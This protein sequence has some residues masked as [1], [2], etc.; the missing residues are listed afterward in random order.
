MTQQVIVTGA[1][2]MLGRAVVKAAGAHGLDVV[3]LAGHAA[4]DIGYIRLVETVLGRYD[5]PL[6]INCA[7]VVPPLGSETTVPDLLHAQMWRANAQG[8]HNLASH[9]GRLVHVST[10]CVFDGRIEAGGYAED[11]LPSPVTFYGTSKLAGEVI[12]EPH[13][14]VRASFIG[15]GRRGLVRW[16]LDQPQGA[17]IPG[18]QD[19]VWNGWYVAD[20]ADRL[21]TLAQQARLTGLLHLPGP[22]I[23]TKGLLVGWLAKALRPDLTVYQRDAGHRRMVLGSHRIVRSVMGDP[24]RTAIMR[25][26]HDLRHDPRRA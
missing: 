25:L 5:Q 15:I 22:Q 23:L 13:L 1:D 6:V 20:F 21:V 14:T 18:F 10:D 17:D 4:C 26:Q 19:W 9:A 7:G 2:G 8:P 3:G 11:A 24:W 16:I 12:R